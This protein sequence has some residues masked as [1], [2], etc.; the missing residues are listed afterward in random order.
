MDVAK[1][2]VC[3]SSQSVG[4]PGHKHLEVSEVEAD[5]LME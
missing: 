2:L 1:Q 3:C 5:D 4:S